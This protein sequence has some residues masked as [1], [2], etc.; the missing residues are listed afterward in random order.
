METLKNNRNCNELFTFHFVLQYIV[1]V[2]KVTLALSGL[3][4]QMLDDMLL[5]QFNLNP[6]LTLE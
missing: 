1:H 6:A 2:V 3:S 4:S 5:H